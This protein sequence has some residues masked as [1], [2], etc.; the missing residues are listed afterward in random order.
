MM[1]AS[2][3]SDLPLLLALFN[4]P[5]TRI[6]RHYAL[7]LF[8]NQTVTSEQMFPAFEQQEGDV[9]VLR[10]LT[11]ANGALV[12]WGTMMPHIYPW[13]NPIYQLHQL[14]VDC[15]LVP[16]HLD[17]TATLLREVLEHLPKDHMAT[18]LLAY[19]SLDHD[20]VPAA[21]E[22]NGFKRIGLHPAAYAEERGR[23]SDVAMYLREVPPRR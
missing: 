7:Q 9:A 5:D 3:R 12:G 19:V 11:G 23:S 15:Y 6:L 13:P 16:T 10:C 20:V 8:G 1:R 21:Y 14:V 18:Q 4:A 17:Q 2:Q 22:A